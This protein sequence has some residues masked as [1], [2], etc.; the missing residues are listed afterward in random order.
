MAIK[1]FFVRNQV[2]DGASGALNY[3]VYL[4]DE[5]H[6]NHDHRTKCVRIL[7][8]PTEIALQAIQDGSEIDLRNKK[9]R[10]GGRPVD[11]YLQSYVMSPPS[12]A[13]LS[14]DDWKEISKR[15]LKEIAFKLD[16]PVKKLMKHC[17]IYLHDQENAHLNIVVNRCIDAES[18]TTILTRPSTTN[19]IKRAFNEEMLKY[20]YDINEYIPENDSNDLPYRRATNL[21]QR[22]NQIKTDQKE[23]NEDRK[24][25]RL[26]DKLEQ[27]LF[28]QLGSLID[29]YD[30]KNEKRIKSTKNRIDK[31]LDELEE[32]QFTEKMEDDKKQ[33]LESI[34]TAVDS[35]NDKVDEKIKIKPKKQSRG[36]NPLKIKIKDPKIKDPEIENIENNFDDLVEKK[37]GN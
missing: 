17:S 29:Y 6:P 1:S 11:A 36:Q 21:I 34:Y 23:I 14:T 8:D 13:N 15:M 20:G 4:K 5:S 30:Q 12:S 35:F 9:K 27:K 32:I 22:E 26:F 25:L 28:K 16:M 31:T 3:A 24:G 19:A 7:N 33:A 2:I 18:R 10:A 37:K